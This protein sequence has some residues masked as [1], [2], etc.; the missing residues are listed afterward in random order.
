MS[1]C[2]CVC[3]CVCVYV[4]VCMCMCASELP[5]TE[6]MN[7]RE[8]GK[9]NETDEAENSNPRHVVCRMNGYNALDA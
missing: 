9:M 2:L 7:E 3:M 5:A 1:M 8:E 6:W 4:C